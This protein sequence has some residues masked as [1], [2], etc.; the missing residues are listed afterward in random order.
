MLPSAQKV[1]LIEVIKTW[2]LQRSNYVL[3]CPPMNGERQVIEFL[4]SE[5]AIYEVIGDHFHKLA[6]ASLDTADFKTEMVFAKSVARSWAVEDE[7]ADEQ[8]PRSVLELACAAVTKQG[9]VPILIVHRFHEALDKLGEDIGSALRDLEHSH[10]LKTVVTMPV[11]LTV[12]RERWEA[13]ESNKAPFLASDWGQGHR[14]K[15]LKGYSFA[16]I[17]A[18][19]ISKNIDVVACEVLFKSSGGVV[20]VVDLLVD[21]V[22]GKRGRGLTLYLQQRSP[23]I[24]K[25]LLDWLDPINTSN[26]YKKSLVSLLNPSFYPTALAFVMD[27]DWKPIL[28]NKEGALGFEMLAWAAASL[29]AKSADPTWSKTLMMLYQDENFDAAVDMIEVLYGADKI[30]GS[31]WIAL[32]DLT[33]FCKFTN[34]VFSN[35]DQWAAAR[36]KLNKLLSSN[37]LP[38]QVSK[39]FASLECWK[40]ISELLS[41][42]LSCKK[43]QP[44]LR[45]ENFVCESGKRENILPFLQLLSLRLDA[46][47]SH[48]T[49]HALQSV[50]TAPESLLQ[51]YAF[52]ELN[53]CFWKFPGL[54]GDMDKKLVEFAKKPYSLRPGLLG[55]SD[56]AHLIALYGEM[57]SV[58][59]CLISGADELSNVLSK[60]EVRKESSH[61]TAFAEAVTCQK[62]REFLGGLIERYFEILSISSTNKTLISPV[63]CVLE[64][65]MYAPRAPI[66]VSM[67]S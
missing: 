25:R 47:E 29:I 28:L 62:Y 45:I 20:G 15:V 27:H 17:V 33:L 19:G 67:R 59:N 46:A 41:D 16:E 51:V 5:R 64:L 54:S 53:I 43:V 35:S 36:R 30:N 21:E 9:R 8:D 48:D 44:E 63:S 57:G 60:Y 42:F 34:D 32:R 3:V 31:Y 1:I 24:C 18:I 22:S 49:F 13:M 26:T 66:A 50:M 2:I 10:Y 56:L 37:A 11:S 38:Q 65:L 52:F 55:Y 40:P 4:T 58:P 12:L 6:I 7:V 61:S 23:E 39:C 14:N